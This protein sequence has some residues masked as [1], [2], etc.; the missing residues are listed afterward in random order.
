MQQAGTD[1]V[2]SCMT[3]NGNIAMA[4]A[5]QQYGL[6]VHQLWLTVATTSDR[7]P[8]TP[9]SCR[10]STSTSRQRALRGGQPV[11]S[12]YPGMKTYLTAMKK[13]EPAYTYNAV[14]LQG[15]Q[16]AALLA[17]GIKAAGKNLT[18]ANVVSGH[19]PDS[20]ASPPAA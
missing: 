8:S 5:I 11:G 16:S 18:Q 10:A 2:L 14:A 12:T 7:E 17:A 15:W 1:F 3:V 13:Y 20:P 4:R 6:K 9:S 19:Q